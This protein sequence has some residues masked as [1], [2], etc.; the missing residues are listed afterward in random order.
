MLRLIKRLP[1]LAAGGAVVWFLDPRS[2]AERRHEARERIAELTG[3]TDP[4]GAAL[5]ERSRVEAAA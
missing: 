1:W 5:G 2:G 4:S 3:R